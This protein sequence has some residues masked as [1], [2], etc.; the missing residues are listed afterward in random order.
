MNARGLLFAC[1]ALILGSIVVIPALAFLGVKGSAASA[2]SSMA[3]LG[4]IVTAFLTVNEEGGT[5]AR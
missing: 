1:L 4:G 5:G 2:L 3:M